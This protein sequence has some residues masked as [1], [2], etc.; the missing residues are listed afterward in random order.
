MK[1][2]INIRLEEIRKEHKLSRKGLEEI[3][4]FK[5]RTIESYER[6]QNPPSIEYIEF[7]S[8][9]FG[10][11][12][13]YIE[14]KEVTQKELNEEIATIFM[15][16]KIFNYDDEKMADLLSIDIEDYK[17]I[18]KIL[19]E[20][21]G[22][23]ENLKIENQEHLTIFENLPYHKV[24]LKMIYRYY[25]IYIYFALMLNINLKCFSG[26]FDN[27]LY[28]IF[29]DNKNNRQIK[30]R[31]LNDFITFI[32]YDLPIYEQLSKNYDNGLDITTKYYASIIKQRNQPEI[33]TPDTQKESIPDKYKEILELLPYAS[34]SFTQNLK[35]KL[36]ELKKAQQIEDL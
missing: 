14:G 19:Y 6:G 30:D 1:D 36:L 4:G 12:K 17:E 27:N 35:N 33:I 9:Y 22:R 7:I 11:K 13:E 20:I 10:Y 26:Q 24:R 2:L 31:G 34:D 23:H 18:I 3:S 29:E 21:N 16:Q 8:L 5:A 28:F 25:D 15:Y 32:M